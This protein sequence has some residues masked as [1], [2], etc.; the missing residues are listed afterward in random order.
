VLGQYALFLLGVNR[1]VISSALN[2][3]QGSIRS[4]VLA[5][6]NRGLAGFEDQRTK[7]SSFNPHLPEHLTELKKKS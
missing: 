4:L 6:K 7:S 3:P 5:M 2:I 1:S